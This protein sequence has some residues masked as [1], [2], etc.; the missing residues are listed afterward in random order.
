MLKRAYLAVALSALLVVSGCNKNT[1]TAIANASVN[2]TGPNTAVTGISIDPNSDQNLIRESVN[3]ICVARKTFVVKVLPDGGGY[4]SSIL[5]STGATFAAGDF[6]ATMNGTYFLTVSTIGNEHKVT[7]KINVTGDCGGGPSGN[8]PGGFNLSANC[9]V[10]NSS[11]KQATINWTNSSG[12]T[13]Y[14]VERR[15]WSTGAWTSQGNTNSTTFSQGVSRDADYYYRVWALSSGGETLSSPGEILGCGGDVTPPPPPPPGSTYSISISPPS[16]SGQVGT[17]QQVTVTCRENGVQ[18]ACTP[19]W[20]T[21]NPS[22]VGVNGNGLVSYLSPGSATITATWMG[23]SASGIFTA[24]ATPAAPL[25]TNFTVNGA[26]SVNVV[27]GTVVTLAWSSNSAT[28]QVVGS[29]DWDRP[30]LG[31]NGSTTIIPNAATNVYSIRCQGASGTTPHVLSVT[32]TTYEAP[33]SCPTVVDY[34]PAGGSLAVGQSRTLTVTGLP[35]GSPCKPFWGVDR[36]DLGSLVGSDELVEIEGKWYPV[37]RNALIKRIASGTFQGFIQPSIVN[38]TKTWHTW[39]TSTGSSV[40]AME[41]P[42]N[43]PRLMFEVRTDGTVWYQGHKVE[44]TGPPVK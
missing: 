8:G 25:C 13:S 34:S 22:S 29:G 24:T 14:R 30:S 41:E 20:S 16:G 26:T 19:T 3:G 42:G 15:T 6:A 40:S 2:V 28:Q 31:L 39:T 43:K 18:V 10:I 27:R 5:P 37:G 21:N 38:D 9:T 4:S 33:A 35:S 17:T 32:V 7:V 44:Q 1:A 23:Q 11:Q 12:A 36:P